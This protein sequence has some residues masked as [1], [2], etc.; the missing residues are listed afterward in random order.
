MCIRD[1]FRAGFE[2]SLRTD[3]VGLASLTASLEEAVGA[4]REQPLAAAPDVRPKRFGLSPVPLAAL[5]LAVWLASGFAVWFALA[6]DSLADSA[7]MAERIAAGL[8]ASGAAD[9]LDRSIGPSG[10]EPVDADRPDE[11]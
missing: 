7:R 4:R 2:G 5:G 3:T 8:P 1:S 11:R 9:P 10:L 6:G